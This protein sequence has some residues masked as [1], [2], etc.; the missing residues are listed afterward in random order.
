ML[1][2]QV[3]LF[4]GVGVAGPEGPGA[5]NNAVFVSILKP[6][7]E[8]ERSAHELMAAARVALGKIPG[9]KSRVFDP[10][11]FFG[12]GGAGEFEFSMRGNVEIDELDALSE[13][14]VRELEALPG[15]VDLTRPVLLD[16]VADRT[17]AAVD[18]WL[19]AQPR[20]GWPESSRCR[21]WQCSPS[22]PLPCHWT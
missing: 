18:S 13:R 17:G 1:E 12:G 16:V 8:R 11:Q 22:R 6:Q 3:V 21:W 7:A 10:S 14:M 5:V 19:S 9:L 4:A 20:A 15:F 2:V